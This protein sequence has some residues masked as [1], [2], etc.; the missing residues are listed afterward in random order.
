MVTTGVEITVPGFQPIV[1]A[2]VIE[3]LRRLHDF[4][5]INDVCL[6]RHQNMFLDIYIIIWKRSKILIAHIPSHRYKPPSN[7]GTDAGK[8]HLQPFDEN[9]WYRLLKD[10]QIR[11]VWYVFHLHRKYGFPKV[12]GRLGDSETAGDHLTTKPGRTP[13]AILGLIGR[14]WFLYSFLIVRGDADTWT[15]YLTP[16]A[17]CYL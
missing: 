11:L 7:L 5:K 13:V 12:S 17:P 9:H 6:V 15:P 2:D 14:A 4:V 16:Y 3:C 8:H 10:W 1:Q